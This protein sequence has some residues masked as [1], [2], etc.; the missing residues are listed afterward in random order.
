VAVLSFFLFAACIVSYLVTGS[1]VPSDSRDALIFQNALLFV[2]LGSAIIEHKFTRPADSV[3]NSLMGLVTLIT[4]YRVAPSTGWWA[5]FSY[6]G[7]VF[8]ASVACVASSSG[9]E[10][11]GWQRTIAS[12]TYRP[13]VV[14][15]KARVLFSVLFLF[16]VFTFYG[17][18]SRS[19]AILIVFWGTFMALWPLQIPELL[20]AFKAYEPTRAIGHVVRTDSPGII[21]VQLQ[22]ESTWVTAVPKLYQQA[23]GSQG[24][25]IPLYVQ[26]LEDS[27]LG[28]GLCAASPYPPK[29]G[30][31]S[32]RVYDLSER[33]ELTDEKLAALLGGSP[34]SRLIGFVVEG[35]SILSI[36]LETWRPD[37]CRE[38]LLVCADVG[39]SRVYYQVIEGE[40]RE[41][42]L[43]ADRH[44]YQVAIATQLGT[45]DPKNGFQRF[46][47]LPS[48]NAPV[49][50]ESTTFGAQIETLQ[51]GDFCYG[52]IP[53]SEI[54]VGGP[55][56]QSLDHHTAILGVTGSGKTELAFDLV[57]DAVNQGV[58]VVCI[59]LT[60]RYQGR[61]VDL[62]PQNLSI[63]AGLS[64]EL[65]DKLFE[66][67]VGPYG[68]GAEKKALKQF[69]D[70]LRVQIS[71]T[72]EGFLTSSLPGSRVG[73]IPLE[74]ISNTRATLYITDLYL[75]CLL[76]FARD[77]PQAFPKT[78]VVVEEAHTVMPEPTTMGLGDFDSR[79]IVGKISQIALQGRKYRVGL[80]IIAQRTATVSK[81]VLT[82]CNTV[83]SLPCFDETSLAFLGNIYGTAY[84]SLI[85][86]LPRLHA[87]I[88]GK[89]V[90][91]ER[92]LII[93]IPYD[94]AK[95]ALDAAPGAVASEVHDAADS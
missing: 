35:S 61:L 58:K 88:F 51:P 63:S 47:W 68:A 90:R 28:T 74:E 31:T 93:R 17:L 42:S 3:V 41:E 52:T 9:P 30:L 20:S 49:F 6:C 92:P 33:T 19:A 10:Q 38:G 37:L 87:L 5:A 64:K 94:A 75:T 24:L 44:G 34:R 27:L 32:G 57:R 15:G 18:Q 45:L 11:T 16:G 82:Q 12:V 62:Q 95:A 36:K 54:K 40:T 79:G 73:I 8:I 70:R 83:I 13:A 91:S 76:H 81:T 7:A 46:P 67:E 55:F 60:A 29:T 26:T 65:G 2:V 56:V 86:N 53:G 50:A 14:F 22:P 59:D 89:G 21:R 84:A 66:A 23:D 4:V 71:Q 72:L 69:A 80:L 85:P 43:Q 25:V 48:M 77:N 78:L 1:I 39:G